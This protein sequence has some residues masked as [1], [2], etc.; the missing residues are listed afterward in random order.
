MISLGLQS[1]ETVSMLVC[2]HQSEVQF[3]GH[4]HNHI[5]EKCIILISKNS[6]HGDLEITQNL[7]F[8]LHQN[9]FGIFHQR[10][11]DFYMIDE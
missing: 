7:H 10:E 11:N 2:L 4:E 3:Q 8:I 1:P 6:L 9:C 5:R